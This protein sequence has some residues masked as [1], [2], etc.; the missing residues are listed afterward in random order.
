MGR[1]GVVV[2]WDFRTNQIEPPTLANG[3]AWHPWKYPAPGLAAHLQGAAGGKISPI[4][5][6]MARLCHPLIT[7]NEWDNSFLDRME[8]LVLD[9]IRVWWS[10]KDAR[11]PHSLL[12]PDHNEE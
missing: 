12:R 5:A 8:R 3:D 6:S 10:G 11:V 7:A 1:R 4:C 2:Y 9:E